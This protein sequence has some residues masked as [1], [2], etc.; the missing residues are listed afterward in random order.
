MAKK[1]FENCTVKRRAI[2]EGIGDCGRE[3]GK[4]CRGYTSTACFDEPIE[5]CKRCKLHSLN[6][7]GGKEC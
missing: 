4:G 3:K 5:K 7:E 1:T 6:Y 2:R